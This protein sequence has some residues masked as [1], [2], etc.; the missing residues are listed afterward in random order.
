MT[1][2]YK[3]TVAPRLFPS[4]TEA[5]LAAIELPQGWNADV[6]LVDLTGEPETERES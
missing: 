2:V 5:A 3:V 1:T 4:A 6:E